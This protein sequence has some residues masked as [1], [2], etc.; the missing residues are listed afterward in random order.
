MAKKKAKK[1]AS[2]KKTTKRP[3]RKT[4]RKKSAAPRK[5]AGKARPRKAKAGPK[6]KR[7]AKK[8][9]RRKTA[10]KKAATK[11]TTA[12]RHRSK[13][14]RPAK[15]SH[16]AAR[17]PVRPKR[18]RHIEPPAAPVVDVESTPLVTPPPTAVPPLT[19][20]ATQI[21]TAYDPDAEPGDVMPVINGDDEA[22]DLAQAASIVPAV[23]ELA[24][25]FE[26]P[27]ER[28]VT[29]RLSDYRGRRV[30]LYFYP[31]D[32]T[33]G[34]TAEACGFRDTLGA[35]TV[36]NAVVLGISP[37]S[38]DSHRQFVEKY[39]LTF[40]LLADENH[41]VAEN[42]GVWRMKQ[43]YG[44]SAMGIVRSTFLVGEDGRIV[45]H[46]EDVQPDGHSR[47]VLEQLD[48]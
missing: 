48:R 40:P 30:V 17:H 36:R 43:R 9:T 24:P 7:A 8:A 2:R 23:G 4:A 5:A 16:A 21:S 1:T 41:S 31:K 26:L 33:P 13:V 10:P 3:A 12:A 45:Q 35:F 22:T 42:Y 37:D 11:K 28:G 18:T 46:W 25:D 29:H 32:D 14:K 6:A 19:D 39:G 27:D 47:E 34:C 44:R 38:V 20:P 15:P